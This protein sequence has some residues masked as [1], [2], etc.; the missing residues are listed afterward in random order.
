M[1]SLSLHKFLCLSEYSIRPSPTLTTWFRTCRLRLVA[2]QACSW[3][4]TGPFKQD[5]EQAHGLIPSNI[6]P[7][8]YKPHFSASEHV[9]I[10]EPARSSVTDQVV[11]SHYATSPPTALAHAVAEF[12]KLNAH[13]VMRAPQH[14]RTFTLG[15]AGHPWAA[16]LAA[17]QGIKVVAERVSSSSPQAPSTG[18]SSQWLDSL[19]PGTLRSCMTVEEQSL[20]LSCFAVSRRSLVNAMHLFDLFMLFHS[21]HKSVMGINALC[22]DAL[23]QNF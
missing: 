17:L 3:A 9:D 15:H 12:G 13:S 5:T 23:L 22:M 4:R 20:C 14:V 18:S 8:I 1:S 2:Q 16:R 7:D 11:F 10:L 19:L 6:L 21:A